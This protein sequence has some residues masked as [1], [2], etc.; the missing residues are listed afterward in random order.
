MK[1]IL[2]LDESGDHNLIAMDPQHPIFVLGGI[3]VY[4]DYAFGEMTNKLNKFKKD[5]F[6]TIDITLHTAD[7][8][9]QKNGFERMKDKDFCLEFYA[10]LNKLI[11]ELNITVLACAIKKQQHMEKYGFEAL[12]PYH[13]SLNILIERF[14]LDIGKN[15]FSSNHIVA[16][17]RDPILDKQLDLAWV[18]LQTSGT[19]FMQAIEIKERI[20]SLILKNKKDRIAGLEIADAIVTPIARKI[21]KRD[22]KVDFEIIKNKMRKNHLGEVTEY[23]LVVLPKK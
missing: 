3:I 19:H 12:D 16:E 2:F 15:S 9:R 5:L 4:E 10:K 21:L 7:F 13:L 18:N 11:S 1:K 23:G 22:S 14:C 6:G 20:N 17:A 8:T